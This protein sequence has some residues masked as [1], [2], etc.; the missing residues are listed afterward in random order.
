[1]NASI[2]GSYSFK[3]VIK[4]GLA[5]LYFSEV[6]EKWRSALGRMI[7]IVDPSKFLAEIQHLGDLLIG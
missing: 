1:M 2:E 3:E 6:S 5:H 4:N 7:A